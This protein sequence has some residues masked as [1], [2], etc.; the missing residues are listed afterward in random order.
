MS[1]PA[2]NEPSLPRELALRVALAARALPETSAA[3]MLDILDGAVGLPLTVSKLDGLT[4]KSLRKAGGEPFLSVPADDLKTAIAFL[5]GRD[6]AVGPECEPYAEGDMPGSLRVACAS[7]SGELLD[8]HFGSCGFFLIYQVS[9]DEVRLIDRRDATIGAEAAED[10]PDVDK[11][12]LRAAVI[13]D[14]QILYVVSIGGPPVAKVVRA[15]VHPIK[16]PGGGE[17]RAI[18]GELRG[19]LA[20]SPPPWLAKILGAAPEAR[21]RFALEEEGGE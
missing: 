16:R 9:P 2:M 3:S 15:G 11:N 18:V 8:G 14:C 12:A 1:E 4:L 5:K 17:A 13:A 7:N 10:D 19:V 21:A 20:G 6:G